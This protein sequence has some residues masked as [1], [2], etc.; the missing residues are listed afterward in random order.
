MAQDDTDA[1]ARGER[2]VPPP[3]PAPGGQGGN[4]SPTIPLAPLLNGEPSPPRA[5]GMPQQPPVAPP[6]QYGAP[7]P[8][9]ATPQP[10]YATPQPP[11]A[12][13]QPPYAT[14]QPNGGYPISSIAPPPARSSTRANGLV[15]ALVGGLLAVIIVGVAVI[16]GVLAGGAQTPLAEPTGISAPTPR[17]SSAP[18]DPSDDSG[19]APDTEAGAEIADLLQAKA[20]EYKRLRDSGALWQSIPDTEFNR[21]AVSAFL[22]FLTDMKVA[23]IWGVDA[24]TAAE[25]EQRMAMLEEKLLAQQ[26]LG[27]DIQITL[28]EG[29]VFRYDGETGEGG[30]FEE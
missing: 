1:E 20:D 26:P 3:P 28:E 7:Q 21:T 9:Y 10:P 14:P 12:T 5:Y 24:Q 18:S 25:Y 8:P 11:Y 16:I 2:V 22:Y 17:P 30:Y 6:P 27:D 15:L 23:T 29:R 13:P 4:A 19:G